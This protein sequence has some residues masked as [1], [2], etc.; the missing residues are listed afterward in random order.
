VPVLQ[1]AINGLKKLSKGD[2]TE[3]KSIY[4][5]TPCIYTLMQCVCI[6]LNIEPRLAK[7]AG[8]DGKFE[9][10]WWLTS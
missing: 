5:P 4:K 9:I 7:K 8:K 10:D 3:L 6:I 1:D 2:I